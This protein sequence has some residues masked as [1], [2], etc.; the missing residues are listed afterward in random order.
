MTTTYTPTDE[1][2]AHN[3]KCNLRLRSHMIGIEFADKWQ[4]WATQS[5]DETLQ[6]L[7]DSAADAVRAVNARA[8]ALLAESENSDARAD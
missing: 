8:R 1:I 3:A 2:K 7:V 4:P 6:W 5:G